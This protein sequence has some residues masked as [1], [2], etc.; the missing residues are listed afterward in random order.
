[1]K[2]KIYLIP[3]PLGDNQPVEVLPATVF[4]VINSVDYYMVENI[5][6]AR[7][8]LRKAGIAK[9]IS[10]LTFFELN[11]KTSYSEAVTYLSAA[12]EGKNMGIISE[13]GMPGIADPGSEAVK[14]AHNKGLEVVPLVGPS[15]ILLALTASGMNGQSFA[16]SGY[17]PIKQPERI[18]KIRQLETRSRNENQTQIFME[19]P[20]RNNPLF[21]DILSTCAKNTRICVA[22][23][24]TLPS[25]FIQT[26]T[27][28]EWK[29]KL[30]E[31]HKRPTIF[32]L[33]AIG[34]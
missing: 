8:F 20:Y 6:S 31:L 19:T 23:D 32:I 26:K 16:F 9:S 1:M 12:F 10:D 34:K 21:K 25:E 14:A 3:V 24:I 4:S 27:V 5:R 28:A 2:G 7:R 33:D 29:N 17:L 22:S 15:S 13:A 11:K 18:K 30:P